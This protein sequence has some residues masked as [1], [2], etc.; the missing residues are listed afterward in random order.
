MEEVMATMR[1]RRWHNRQRVLMRAFALDFHRAARMRNSWRH[2]PGA[3]S[4]M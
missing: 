3:A 1:R 2:L 4:R